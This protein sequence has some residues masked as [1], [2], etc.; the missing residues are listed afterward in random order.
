M[1]SSRFK[2]IEHVLPCQHVREYPNATRTSAP[3]AL[4]LAIKQY[5]PLKSPEPESN[6]VTVI[7]AHANGFPKV[8]KLSLRMI[9]DEY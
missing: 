5:V 2:V 1:S 3:R 6:A 8:C 9:V 4:K 7:A